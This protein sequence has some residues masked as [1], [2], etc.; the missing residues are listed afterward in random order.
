MQRPVYELAKVSE[1]LDGKFFLVPGVAE[2]LGM[3]FVNGLYGLLRYEPD[4]SL[5]IHWAAGRNYTVALRERLGIYD[6]LQVAG[7]GHYD[8]GIRSNADINHNIVTYYGGKPEQTIQPPTADAGLFVSHT[9]Y[10][11]DGQLAEKENINPLGS[12]SSA[13][14][15]RKIDNTVSAHMTLLDEEPQIITPL[16][17][18]RFEYDIPDQHGDPQTAILMLVPAMGDRFDATLLRPLTRVI[19]SGS[20]AGFETQF[21]ERYASLLK[22]CFETIGLSIASAHLHNINHNQPTAGNAAVFKTSDGDM[23]PY[24][25]DWDTMTRPSAE[26]APYA[27]ALDL[28]IAIQSNASVI[29]ALFERGDIGNQSASYAMSMTVVGILAGYLMKMGRRPRDILSPRDLAPLIGNQMS[30][31]HILNHLANLVTI[32]TLNY[33]NDVRLKA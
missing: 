14:A 31:N 1:P 25:T 19:A 30:N 27:R 3:E 15:K 23:L 18:G 28:I 29:Y 9:A 2:K 8:L 17:V 4:G 32:P 20:Y 24:L 7:G 21:R 10:Y 26:D 22:S 12:Y 13:S 33:A 5:P 11:E 16:Y 6:C